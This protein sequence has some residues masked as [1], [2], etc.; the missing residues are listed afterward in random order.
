M[1]GAGHT[2]QCRDNNVNNDGIDLDGCRDV[3]VEHCRIKSGDDGVCLKSTGDH[4]Y[5]N[6]VIRQDQSK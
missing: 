6:N 5:P 3:L 2:K 4:P 1:F